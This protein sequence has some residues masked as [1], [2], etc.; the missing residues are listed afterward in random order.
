MKKQKK[1]PQTT[2]PA[3]R[4]LP[5]LLLAAVLA[6]AGLA[7]CAAPAATTAAAGSATTAPVSAA[8]SSE[9]GTQANGGVQL[10][11][12]ENARILLDENPAAVL[13]DVRTEEEYLAGHIPG[14]LLLPV[15]ELADRLDELPPDKQTILVV[16]CRTGRRSA[17]AAQILLEAG[18]LAIY[19]LGGI[20]DWPYETEAG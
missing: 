6:A 3:R 19:D 8:A 13:I 11:S 20:A 12:P 1:T 18:Y 14:S 17:I 10:I 15:E 2:V 9:T 4:G 16:Y 5:A 7:A